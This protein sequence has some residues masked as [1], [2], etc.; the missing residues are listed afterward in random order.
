MGLSL[1]QSHDPSGVLS[2]SRVPRVCSFSAGCLHPCQAAEFISARS[3]FPAW[4]QLVWE[5]SA[6]RTGQPRPLS[7]VILRH[8]ERWARGYAGT[9]SPPQ[10]LSAVGVPRAAMRGPGRGEGLMAKSP[11]L[12]VGTAGCV[13]L[14]KA[15]VLSHPGM[16]GVRV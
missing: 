12:L 16:Q 7:A 4:P 15:L 3:G 2:P 1:S 5:K 10:P 9:A 13:S 6:V 11:R 8:K 14:G